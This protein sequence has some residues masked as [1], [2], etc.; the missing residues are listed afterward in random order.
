M[1]RIAFLF[2]LLA[3]FSDSVFAQQFS[4]NGG[5]DVILV[6]PSRGTGG[7]AIVHGFGNSLVMNFEDDFTGGTYL[8]RFAHFAADGSAQLQAGGRAE[9]F[10]LL[11]NG[12]LGLGIVQAGSKLHIAGDE[13]ITMGNYEPSNGIK[14]ISFTGYRDYVPNYFGASIEATPEWSCCGGYPQAGY[15]GIKNISLNFMMHYN[16]DIGNSKFAAMSIRSNGDV[17]IGTTTPREKLSVNGNIR[18]REIKVDALNWPDFVFDKGYKKMSLPEMEA[19]I[20]TNKHLPGVPSAATV[21]KNGIALGEMNKVLLQRLEELTLHLIEKDK[22][23]TSQQSEMSQ[24][25]KKLND[26]EILIRMILKKNK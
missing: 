14:G 8:G 7:R 21:E 16:Q 20:Q 10:S 18:S 15:A 2:S 6:S 24:V 17:G 23:I 1:K 13:L 9:S 11:T 12:N 4:F 19:F 5:A 26:Q 3:F 22:Q 25:V